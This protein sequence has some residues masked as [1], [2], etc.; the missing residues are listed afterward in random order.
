MRSQ[1][2]WHPKQRFGTP[3]RARLSI[4]A[5]KIVQRL[6]IEADP[7]ADLV[8]AQSPKDSPL[9]RRSTPCTIITKDQLQLNLIPR[10][11]Q[12]QHGFTHLY[13]QMSLRRRK[14]NL[15]Y[16]DSFDRAVVLSQLTALIPGA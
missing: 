14:K 12:W 10:I 3:S 2:A 15:L 8:R 6:I 16:V 1:A 7:C 13:P 4:R 5:S 11:A 9:H